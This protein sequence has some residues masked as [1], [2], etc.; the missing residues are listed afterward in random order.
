[1]SNL[2]F[3]ENRH[4]ENALT[5]TAM[6]IFC[7]RVVALEPGNMAKRY[8]YLVVA[9]IAGTLKAWRSNFLFK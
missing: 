7:L 8:I 4:E 2:S 9:M 1:M 3:A 6:Q 5:D